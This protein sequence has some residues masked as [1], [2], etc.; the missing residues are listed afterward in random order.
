MRELFGTDGVRGKANTYPIIPE[1]AL[2]LGKAAA[3]AFKQ[4]IENSNG[5]RR[6]II[7]GKDTRL[8]GYMLE[9]ALTSGITSMGVDVLLVGPMPTP[10]IAHLVR[11]FAADAGIMISASHNPA[12]DNGIK[13]FGR[14]GFKLPDKVEE[15]IEELALSNNTKGDHITGGLIGKAYR[16]NDASGRYIEFSKSS[17]DN[18]SLRGL[19]IVLD[20]ANGAAY[21]IAPKVFS[22]L[23]AEV[24]VL[25]DRPDGLN[26]NLN[27]GALHP[28]VIQKAVAEHKADI[29]IA[30]DGD[31]DRVIL[32][33][34]NSS[35][36]NGDAVMT[37][38]AYELDM[39]GRLAKKTVVA[40]TMSNI[41][42]EIAL[43]KRN[44]RLVRTPVGDRYVIDAMRA[45]GYNFGGEQCGHLVFLDHNTTG[46]GILT[47]LQVLS[48]MKRNHRRLSE[49]AADFKKSPQIIVNVDVREKK[50]FEEMP[51]IA[52]L[53]KEVEEKLGNTGRLV[54]RYSG[55]QNVA[56]IM[57]EGH[58]EASIKGLAEQL[59]EA[60]K[61]E[62]F[63]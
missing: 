35:I 13:F 4:N 44:I 6:S 61:K 38:C 57:L 8:S 23:G 53:S 63:E 1:I 51:S 15:Q 52:K 33:D 32:A 39:A 12:E 41:G 30:L 42:L 47:A 25:N 2:R 58:D 28:E 21:L 43:K 29:G 10:A 59:A 34:E 11:S 17:I 49:L 46:D 45:H 7:I 54:L 27:C 20:C 5:K 3:E 18:L 56:R 62:N 19:K 26:I 37:M 31:A 48:I 50:P 9:T 60:I 22:E 14:D 16:I 36:V 55:T 24:I 40:T